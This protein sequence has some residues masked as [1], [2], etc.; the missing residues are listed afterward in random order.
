MRLVWKKQLNKNWRRLPLE[1][2]APTSSWRLDKHILKVCL[3]GCCGLTETNSRAKALWL[4]HQRSANTHELNVQVFL[5]E[6]NGNSAAFP[7]QVPS[8]MY[9]DVP[10]TERNLLTSCCCPMVTPTAQPGE[11]VCQVTFCL[12]MAQSCHTDLQAP[13]GLIVR[14][15]WKG[16]TVLYLRR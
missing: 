10:G 9:D 4:A 6:L 12:N 16:F 5:A 1:L 14:P 7:G 11:G 15:P 8:S 2:Q 13:L 3:N